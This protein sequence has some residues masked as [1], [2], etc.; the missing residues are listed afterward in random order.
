MD[1][2]TLIAVDHVLRERSVRGAARA[3]GRPV[4]SIAAAMAR[5][6]GEISLTLVERAGA[7]LVTTLE[8]VRL[9]PEIAA[10]AQLAA[11][12]GAKST[13]KLE[14]LERF[15]QVAAQGSIRRAARVMGLGQPQLTRQLA[16]LELRLGATLLD[17][18]RAGTTLTAVGII[19]AERA[20]ALLSAWRRLSLA[21]ADRYRKSAATARL[22]S[23][24]PLGYES[25]IAGMLA[26]LAARWHKE[27]PRIPLLV[28]SSTA[29]DLL[30]GLKNGH[31][32]AVLLD[33]EILPPDLDGCVISRTALAIVGA[34]SG[35]VATALLSAPL[36]VPSSRSGLR[37][38]INGILEDTL[39]PVER[40][41]VRLVEIDSIP[42]I[43]N[44]VLHHGFVS[45]LPQ[46]SVLRIRGELHQI[47]LPATYDMNFWLCWPRGQPGIA[48]S[49]LAVLQGGRTATPCLVP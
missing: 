29:E 20:T 14:T 10:A 44:M 27:R 43:L 32:D 16:Q 46:A 47:A 1:T 5:L 9:A 49:V 33:T 6:E 19:L 24:I 4:S 7:S 42:V 15:T 34:G 12:L 2:A 23:V 18:S 17:R 36:A 28:S 37:Q 35:D 41:N 3:L 39:T 13:V 22:G 21:S 30:R 8:A 40:S 38:R 45:V 11:Q 25:E 48:P 26:S 31:F